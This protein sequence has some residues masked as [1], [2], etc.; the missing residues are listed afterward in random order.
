MKEK[1]VI[2]NIF[3][4]ALSIILIDQIFKY[5]VHH[6]GG[7]YIC[8]Y[9]ISFGLPLKISFFWLILGILFLFFIKYHKNILR[10]LYTNTT[11][12]YAAGLLIG[13]ILSNIIDRLY[14]TCIIDY[15]FPFWKV[16]PVFNVADIA[17]FIGAILLFLN[18][19]SKGT[20]KCGQVV[21]N[22]G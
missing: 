3:S 17:I 2:I 1:S 16:L 7:L 18:I 19:Y 13:G 21:S 15:I 22:N 11:I 6:V 10:I 9:G 12:K 14:L 8:N 20:K 4:I 5:K